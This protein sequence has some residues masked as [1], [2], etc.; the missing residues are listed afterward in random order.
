MTRGC[1]GAPRTERSDGLHEAGTA[2]LPTAAARGRACRT[3]AAAMTLQARVVL[4]PLRVAR[5]LDRI[6]THLE[7]LLS[8]VVGG[9]LLL[10]HHP[11]HRLE[12]FGA[13]GVHGRTHRRHEFR[14]LAV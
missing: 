1:A 14:R 13:H 6:H 7:A 10:I 12:P 11:E 9:A 5:L 2:A 8:R 3:I 4:R